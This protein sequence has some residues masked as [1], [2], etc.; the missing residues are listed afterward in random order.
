MYPMKMLPAFK[1]YLWGGGQL[2]EKY[3]KQT[4]FDRVAESWELSCYPGSASVVENGAFAGLPLPEVLRLHPEFASDCAG[5]FPLLVKLIDAKQPL[6]LQVH[7]VDEYALAHEKQF[8]KNEM[9]YVMDCEPGAELIVGFWEP[10][11]KSELPDLIVSGSIMD[12]VRRVKVRPGDCYAIPAGMLHAIGAG[13]LIA[14]VQ[15]SSNVTYRVFDYNRVDASGNPRE[16]H[17][18]K[19]VEVLETSL[20]AENSA[21]A[22]VARKDGHTEKLLCDW[23]YFRSTLLDFDSRADLFS[24]GFCCLLVLEGNLRVAWSQGQIAV[25]PG[26]SLFIPAG[27]GGYALIGHGKVLTASV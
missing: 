12:K 22:S 11:A 5:E 3:G 25:T 16:L 26:E 21:S 7:P 19:A 6:S 17:I 20:Q 1:D 24:S 4:D 18:E 10:V 9:W 15:Q 2:K 8:G 13:I 14:E 27:L 23:K